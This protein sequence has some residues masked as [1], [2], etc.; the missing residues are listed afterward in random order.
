MLTKK[1]L[2]EIN[3]RPKK[4]RDLWPLVT[5]G[6]GAIFLAALL[7]LTYTLALALLLAAATCV[8]LVYK[9]A[10]ASHTTSL[11]YDDLDTE[12]G[13]RFAAVQE[14]CEALASSETIWCIAEQRDRPTK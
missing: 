14:A 8:W 10:Q 2:T 7:L 4:G 1:I 13:A 6:T 3:E 11:V 9:R 5:L 12:T